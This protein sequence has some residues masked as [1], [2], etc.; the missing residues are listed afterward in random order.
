[1]MTVKLKKESP[2]PDLDLSRAPVLG[3]C[4]MIIM[5]AQGFGLRSQLES[6]GDEAVRW[7]LL[8]SLKS[9]Y[10]ACVFVRYLNDERLASAVFFKLAPSF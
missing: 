1:M 8:K 2:Q 3:H 10:K 9:V 6:G 7:T 4:C 5:V